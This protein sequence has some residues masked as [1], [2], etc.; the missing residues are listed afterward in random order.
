[1]RADERLNAFE[2][3]LWASIATAVAVGRWDLVASVADVSPWVLVAALGLLVPLAIVNVVVLWRR[4][5]VS[6]TH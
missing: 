6:A 5:V 4:P 3:V 2:T 1:V